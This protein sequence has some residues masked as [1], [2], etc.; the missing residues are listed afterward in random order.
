MK[1]W[2]TKSGYKILQVLSGRS[3]VFMLTFRGKNILIDTGPGFMWKTLD[4]RLKSL[5]VNQTECLILTHTHFDHAAN[6][7][8]IKD[9]FNAKILVHRSEASFLTRGENIVP[10]GTNLI[11]KTMVDLFA[12]RFLSLSRYKPCQY[13]ILIDDTFDLNSIGFNAY[14]LHT[15]GHTTGSMSIIVDNDITLV[16]DTMFGIFKWSVFPPFANDVIQMI[17]S[18]GLLLE[19]NC[20]IFIPS[21]GTANIRQL[22]QKEYDKWIR[23]YNLPKN[24]IKR[25]ETTN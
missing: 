4:K 25:H 23:F 9:K 21:H 12:K 19:T 14:I 7:Q 17:R 5:S 18:W 8:K 3:N 24:Q 20:R 11:A 16:G 1:S 15:P 10:Q 22:V 13:D 2:E 6:A